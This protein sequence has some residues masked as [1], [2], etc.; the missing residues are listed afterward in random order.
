[1]SGPVP[2]QSSNSA[3]PASTGAG[4]PAP[5]TRPGVAII[6]NAHTPY[7]LA[8]HRRIVREMGEIRLWSL[9]THDVSNAPWSLQSAPEINPVMFG[10]GE[11]SDAQDKAGSVLREWKKGGAIILWLRQ[12]DI[13]AVVMMGYNDPGRMRIMR[14]CRRQGM[15][16]LLFGDSNIRGDRARGVKAIVKRLVVERIVRG[17]SGVL[18]CGRL[19]RE[20]FAR[21]GARD[22]RT[23]YFPYEP[24]YSLIERLPASAVES[25]AGRFGLAAGR[26]RIIFSGR[27]IG[28]KRVDLLID[29]FAALAGE[30]PGWDLLIAGDGPLRGELQ[31]RVPPAIAR[32][33]IWTGFIDDQATVSALYRL[34]D[35]LVLP[36]D[37]EPWALVVNEAA[38]AGLAIVCSDVIGAAAE[39]V[40]DGQNGRIF[41]AGD[42]A[43]LIDRLRD[44]TAAEHIA[45]MKAGS[46]PILADWRQRGDPVAGL[47][48]ALK[49]T[50]VI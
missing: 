31:A 9:Y 17:V 43:S 16:C 4:T 36:S 7:R 15:P 12:H 46:A 27:L 23:F 40:R 44:V 38:A 49:S 13:R 20:Y 47:R 37:Y 42:L 11:S 26:Q 22:D 30:R 39:L 28:A 21:Y 1:M 3:L 41:A 25:A 6:A 32:R 45:A 35:V 14:W 2:D 19:G 29:A 10:A 24:D 48:A 8:L 34:S 18:V 50:G 33:V 5:S